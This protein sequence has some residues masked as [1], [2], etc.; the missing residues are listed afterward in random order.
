MKAW[1]DEEELECS[2]E[3]VPEGVTMVLS[4]PAP[5]GTGAVDKTKQRERGGVGDYWAISVVRFVV[6]KHRLIRY[7]LFA[8]QSNK[9]TFDEGIDAV[10][11]EME[12]FGTRIV[13]IEEGS[14][15]KGMY[16]QRIEQLARKRGFPRPKFI[17]MAS[18]SKGKDWRHAQLAGLN[19]SEELVFVNDLIDEGTEE[20]ERSQCRDH[21]QTRFDDLMDALS[22]CTDPAVVEEAPKAEKFIPKILN[23]VRKKTGWKRKTRYVY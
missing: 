18:F 13:C 22:L 7:R 20:I 6:K 8:R 12:N 16:Q 19:S 11:D 1:R 3:E 14:Q 17:N 10:L 15:T 2:F 5:K 21:P 4:D 23:Q 9:W